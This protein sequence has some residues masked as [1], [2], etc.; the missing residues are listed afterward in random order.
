MSAARTEITLD[1]IVPEQPDNSNHTGELFLSEV[2]PQDKPWDKHRSFADTVQSHY[3]GSKFERYGERISFCSQLLE[4]GLVPTDEDTLR[5]KLRSAKFCRVRHCPVCQW[6]RSLMWKAKA[7]Q[8]LP[9]IVEKYPTH[10]WLFVTLTQKNVPIAELRDTLTQMNKGFKR[11][12]ERKAF[13]AIG[14]LRSMEVTRGRDGN[15]HPHF[16]C[17]L[18]VPAS[19]FGAG[20]MKQS[21]WVELWRESM[22]LDYNPVMDVQAVKKGVSPSSLVPELLK[23][24]TKESDMVVDR[25]WFLELTEQLHKMRAIATG[26]VLKQYLREL[27]D[28]PEDL[29]GKDDER[30]L[31]DF[32]RLFFGWKPMAKRYQLVD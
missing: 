21:D 15:A 1:A 5:F 6:R 28:E 4:F 8:V 27:E 31:E 16:H 3:T 11:M 20:Y 14:W 24:C 23:Y 25:A 12:V 30:A 32:G 19:Y 22:R 26:G 17:L 18:L 29:I 10:R 9:K 2:S 7:Y 13:P